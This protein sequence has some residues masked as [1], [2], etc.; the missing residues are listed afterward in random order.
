MRY[1]IGLVCVLALSAMGCSETSGTGGSGGNGVACVDSVC[2]CTEAGIR[3]AIAEGGGPYTFDCDG[4][5]TVTTVA[6]IVIDNDVRLDGESN[7]TVDGDDAHRVFSVLE[8]VAAELR[9][10]T[11]TGGAVSGDVA[12]GQHIGGG[13]ANSGTLMLVDCAISEN[14]AISFGGG[15]SNSRA[16]SITNSTISG[17]SADGGGA[18]LNAAVL[19][20]WNSTVSGNTTLSENI[21]SP[22]GA[23][24]NVGGF[25]D[26]GS[27][28]M[29]S[30]TV[31]GNTGGG[32][33]PQGATTLSSTIVNDDCVDGGSVITSNGYNIE[34]PGDT[35]GLDQPTD[36][37]GIMELQL[38]LEPL[39]D[40]GGPTMT[41]ALGGDSVAIDKIPAEDCVVVE[42][43]LTGEG[44]FECES[45]SLTT[46]QRGQP[47]PETGGTMCDVGSFELSSP[48]RCIGVIG[49]PGDECPC[50]AA[51]NLETGLCDEGTNA[52]QGEPCD[53]G[54]GVCDG[55][56]N[57]V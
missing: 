51:C 2:P 50:T 52:P 55:A 43:V 49:D 34:S 26:G 18:I 8:G 3:A 13:I 15:I 31:S 24:H 12:S 21:G 6:E 23:I 32:I 4:P 33:L 37:A 39:Q 29:S 40:N 27:L 22:S 19:N 48:I 38:D 35:C 9:G 11:V 30:S 56:G 54:N 45:L 44:S 36:Q 20:I 5:Q 46:D 16:L 25:D 7:L 10:F 47:R 1:F 53:D 28:F 41:H 14:S 57:C 17:N 42:C